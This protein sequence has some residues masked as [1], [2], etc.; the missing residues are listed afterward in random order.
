MWQKPAYLP[1]PPWKLNDTHLQFACHLLI[2]IS[3][4]QECTGKFLTWNGQHSFCHQ[5]IIFK[6]DL[7]EKLGESVLCTDNWQNNVNPTLQKPHMYDCRFHSMKKVWFIAQ[8]FSNYSY[9]KTRFSFVFTMINSLKAF[10]K[11][12]HS[13]EHLR[14]VRRSGTWSQDS[15]LLLWHLELGDWNTYLLST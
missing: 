1:L 7:L 15:G 3:G 4:I 6:T 9:E 5:K 13:N 11:V 2:Y 10:E 8:G 14:C 12:R